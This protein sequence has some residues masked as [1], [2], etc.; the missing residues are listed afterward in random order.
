MPA[1]IITPATSASLASIRKAPS[2]IRSRSAA[3]PRT[4]PRS[5]P[6]SAP[7][8]APKRC[9][10]RSTPSSRPISPIAPTARTSS[11]RGGGSGRRPSRRHCRALFDLHPGSIVAN[12]S[13]PTTVL[14]PTAD[15][16]A[17]EA[18]AAA[19]GAVAL[20]FLA[21]GDGRG[22]SLAVLLRERHGFTGEI[23]AV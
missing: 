21:F 9:L 20:R 17:L 2:F 15:A 10:R 3:A 16:A 5:A 14:E 19:G 8:S 23:R 7:A 4:T 13:E 1:A 12:V 22:Y 6:L 18:A 11:P